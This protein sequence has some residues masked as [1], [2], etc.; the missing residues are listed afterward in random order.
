MDR[1]PLAIMETNSAAAGPAGSIRLPSCLIGE[2]A[3][4][5]RLTLESYLED[6][7]STCETVCSSAEAQK[8]LNENTPSVAILD[9]ELKDGPCTTLAAVLRARGVPFLIYSGYP[10]E[11]AC[12]ELRAAP[13]INKPIDRET[14]LRAVSSLAA[15]SIRPGSL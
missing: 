12:P 8:W 14:L 4:L 15:S 10:A 2:G 3:V 9:Y 13:W 11:A 5:I 1:S 6:Q 7:G